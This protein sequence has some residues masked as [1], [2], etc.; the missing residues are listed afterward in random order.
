MHQH[1]EEAAPAEF[2]EPD[3]LRPPVP[4]PEV[5]GRTR[6]ALAAFQRRKEGR[7]A[8]R[9]R[10]QQAPAAPSAAAQGWAA[11]RDQKR[12]EARR[13]D[14]KYLYLFMVAAA[15]LGLAVVQIAHRW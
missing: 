15:L 13:Q 8:K 5:P 1:R 14:R 7:A 12:A 9:Q 2:V 4:A 11:L 6:Q 3:M 10:A